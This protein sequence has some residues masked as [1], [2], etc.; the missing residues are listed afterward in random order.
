[1]YS[2]RLSFRRFIALFERQSDRH[3]E[4]M[5]EGERKTKSHLPSAGLIPKITTAVGAEQS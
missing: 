5:R 3:D 1:M 2:Y 4:G